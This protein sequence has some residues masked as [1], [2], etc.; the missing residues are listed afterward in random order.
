MTVNV[1]KPSVD[2]RKADRTHFIY[3]SWMFDS[4]I[5]VGQLLDMA[6]FINTEVVTIIENV[7]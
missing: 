7:Q 5:S 2:D 3:N 4:S 1:W 6:K